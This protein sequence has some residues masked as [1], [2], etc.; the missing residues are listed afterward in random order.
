MGYEVLRSKS[1]P[2]FCNTIASLD[3]ALQELGPLAPSWTI[4]E[5][6]RK[7]ARK[8]RVDEAEYSQP[9]CTALQIALVN[10]YASIGIRPAT[11]LGHSSGEIAAAYAAGGATVDGE[12]LQD[13]EVQVE[14]HAAGLNFRV[15][16]SLPIILE[17]QTY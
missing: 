14:I 3:K 15:N 1:N 12:A 13:D 10:T 9:L 2:V 4:D 5:E 8:S 7:P 6:L 17:W 16:D 11:V